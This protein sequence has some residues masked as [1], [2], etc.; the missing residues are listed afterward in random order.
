MLK[1]IAY[2]DQYRLE[3]PDDLLVYA[4]HTLKD[5][6]SA[7]PKTLIAPLEK[8][9]KL[10]DQKTR[11]SKLMWIKRMVLDPMEK[12]GW[13]IVVGERRGRRIAVT[14]EGRKIAEV[15]GRMNGYTGR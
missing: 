6:G 3:R 12:K 13:I 15:F 11:N 1:S 7:T 9:G 5:Y 14:G 2:V 4:L 10:Q 8:I